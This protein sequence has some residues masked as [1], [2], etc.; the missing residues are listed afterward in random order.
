MRLDAIRRRLTCFVEQQMATQDANL[1]DTDLLGGSP[2]CPLVNPA[3]PSDL[4][5]LPAGHVGTEEHVHVL[6]TDPY[7][8]ATRYKDF[9][10]AEV[11]T[12]DEEL[13][14]RGWVEQRRITRRK[15]PAADGPF[16]RRW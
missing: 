5:I 9:H 13:V 12:S 10:L 16:L 7:S 11:G 15:G 6:G 8:Q 2:R 14:R 1:Q 4:C 3:C